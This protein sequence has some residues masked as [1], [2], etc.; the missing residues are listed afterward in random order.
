MPVMRKL[1][2]KLPSLPVVELPS[3]LPSSEIVT[4]ALATG[5]LR[6]STRRP[7]TLT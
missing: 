5:R 2:L 3:V 7:F 6:P 1:A 4:L